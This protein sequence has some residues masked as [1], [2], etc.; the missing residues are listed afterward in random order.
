MQTIKKS[1]SCMY[2]S[3]SASFLKWNF[4]CEA[5]SKFF[6]KKAIYRKIK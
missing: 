5:K 1:K 6:T 4:L 2:F 3:I